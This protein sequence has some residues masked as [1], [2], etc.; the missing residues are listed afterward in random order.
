MDLT[1]QDMVKS[2]NIENYDDKL[3]NEWTEKMADAI[4]EQTW[5]IA[6]RKIAS[7]SIFVALASILIIILTA[8]LVS[9]KAGCVTA[10]IT[11]ITLGAMAEIIARISVRKNKDAVLKASIETT[12]NSRI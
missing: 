7:A 1:T 5:S 2:V 12:N 11:F 4:I 9:P 6:L 8:I 3:T 10:V